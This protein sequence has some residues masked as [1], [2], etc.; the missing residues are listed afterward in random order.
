MP[1]DRQSHFQDFVVPISFNSTD[2]FIQQQIRYYLDP[3][4]EA[5][6]ILK[7]ELAQQYFMEHFS[8]ERYV[9]D[10]VDSIWLVKRG[11]R[12][13]RLPYEWTDLPDPLPWDG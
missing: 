12:G 3:A 8:A 1:F 10:V 13:L 7:T 6:R 9:E 5:E 2:E 4:H 11:K